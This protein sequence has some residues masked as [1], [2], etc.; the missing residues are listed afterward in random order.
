MINWKIFWESLNNLEIKRE[1]VHRAYQ[2]KSLKEIIT[3]QQQANL[4][5]LNMI[6]MDRLNK[7]CNK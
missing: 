7:I 6:K 5:L 2:V 3:I 1:D 4:F